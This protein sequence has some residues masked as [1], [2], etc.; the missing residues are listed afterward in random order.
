LYSDT[1]EPYWEIE[2]DDDISKKD[3]LTLLKSFLNLLRYTKVFKE[4]SK[5]FFKDIYTGIDEDQTIEDIVDWWV[6]P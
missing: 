5:D 4:L 6:N 1:N 2:W 3:R